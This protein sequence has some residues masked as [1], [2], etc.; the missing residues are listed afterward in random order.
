[1]G[2]PADSGW[3]PV[4]IANTPGAGRLTA[5]SLQISWKS[6]E[7]TLNGHVRIYFSN[8]GNASSLADMVMINSAHNTED[9]LNYLIMPGF[10][11]IKVRYEPAG[12]TG[13]RISAYINYRKI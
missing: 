9:C 2:A 1:M 11:R 6:A 5:A 12:I 13:G 8:G 7:G 4:E 10:D 3:H